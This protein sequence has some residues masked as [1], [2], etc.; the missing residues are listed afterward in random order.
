MNIILDTETTG[1]NQGVKLDEPIQI[2]AIDDNGDAVINTFVKP[3]VAIDAG[4]EDVHNIT[5]E[6]LA[7]A[8][9]FADV[10]G[11][12]SSILDETNTVWVYN[13][14]FD[15]RILM[16]AAY[17]HGLTF[18][19][20]WVDKFRC[21]MEKYATCWAQPGWKTEFRNAKLVTALEQQGLKPRVD[22]HD[23]LADC[24]MTFDLL[25]HL[26]NGNCRHFVENTHFLVALQSVTH[27]TTDKGV[28]Y[29]SFETVGKQ[30]VNV[31]N[32]QFWILK[33]AGYDLD[34]WLNSLSENETTVLTQPIPAKIK[35]AGK[36]INLA[37][38]ESKSS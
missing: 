4:A 36:Y 18:K 33:Q 28:V 23:A 3:T 6:L 8:P 13:A 34:D 17:A 11:H 14:G 30:T 26:K 15:L 7:T 21:A 37:G 19:R 20:E 5:P 16:N 22:A 1:V 10:Y 38:V 27:K 24:H 29:A 32:G 31:F 25:K 35:Y 12:L 2:S 9:T